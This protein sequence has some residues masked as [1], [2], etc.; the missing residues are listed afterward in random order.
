M[1]IAVTSPRSSM[2][3]LRIFPTFRSCVDSP[4]EGADG[5]FRSASR[6]VA[7]YQVAPSVARSSKML[8]SAANSMVRVRSGFRSGLPG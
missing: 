1:A 5:A 4:D 8:V 7:V 2:P 3:E 6:V